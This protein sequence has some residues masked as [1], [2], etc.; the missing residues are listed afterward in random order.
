MSRLPFDEEQRVHFLNRYEHKQDISIEFLYW[1]NEIS[2][3]RRDDVV[4]HLHWRFPIDLNSNQIDSF[5]RRE[6]VNE[7]IDV[8]AYVTWRLQKI[9]N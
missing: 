6:K 9:V 3:R 7:S 8:I 2:Y 4:L 1:L 5:V